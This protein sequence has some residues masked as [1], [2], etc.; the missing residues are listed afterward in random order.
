MPLLSYFVRVRCVLL[1]LG[2]ALQVISRGLEFWTPKTSLLF[3]H[4]N[5]AFERVLGTFSLVFPGAFKKYM[6]HNSRNGVYYSS[7]R[8]NASL[9]PFYLILI[10]SWINFFYYSYFFLTLNSFVCSFLQGN[11]ILILSSSKRNCHWE[12][13]Y[14]WISTMIATY[15]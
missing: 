10:C 13:H 9:L 12:F 15:F 3:S 4:F 7:I 5:Y 1:V 2:S 6:Y 14:V 11:L 8:V